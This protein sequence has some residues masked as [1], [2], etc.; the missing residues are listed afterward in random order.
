M[1]GTSEGPGAVCVQGEKEVQLLPFTLNPETGRGA[2]VTS[3]HNTFPCT[4]HSPDP[5]EISLAA[6]SQ[7]WE[8]SG[9]WGPHPPTED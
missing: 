2:P 6:S 8:A 9:L 7:I 4:D 3:H 5:K 1:E